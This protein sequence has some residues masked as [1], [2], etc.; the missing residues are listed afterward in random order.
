VTTA[1]ASPTGPPPIDR[2]DDHRV[3][4]ACGAGAAPRLFFPRGVPTIAQEADPSRT[5]TASSPV[6]MS[7]EELHRTR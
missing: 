7:V 3:E 2:S 6:P 5:G 4:L 1:T